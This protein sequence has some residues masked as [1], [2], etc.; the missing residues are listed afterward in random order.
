MSAHMLSGTSL[1]L[2][3]LLHLKPVVDG[4]FQVAW[5]WKVTFSG[6]LRG[7]KPNRN[8]QPQVPYALPHS[9]ES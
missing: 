3:V 7:G 4:D 1:Q 6:I 9:P 8:V 5:M 2:I